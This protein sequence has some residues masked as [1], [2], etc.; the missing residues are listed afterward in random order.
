VPPFA[1]RPYDPDIPYSYTAC[2]SCN[3][4]LCEVGQYR[5][6]CTSTRDSY[7]VSCTNVIPNN[8]RYDSPGGNVAQGTDTS[9][10][11]NCSWQCMNGYYQTSLPPACE[12]CT[13]PIPAG[14]VY[15]GVGAIVDYNFCEWEC[16][17]SFYA[18]GMACKP[19]NTSCLLGE[20]PLPNVIDTATGVR[21]ENKYVPVSVLSVLG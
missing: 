14:A 4:S 17:P 11:S 19:L 18:D 3:V 7:C 2:L 15:K 13:N 12:K 10:T 6:P 9:N 21:L 8:S 20:C 16:P 5:I 1:D